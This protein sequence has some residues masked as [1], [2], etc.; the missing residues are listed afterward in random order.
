[1]QVEDHEES[2]AIL[3]RPAIWPKGNHFAASEDDRI[4]SAL[5]L[6]H[7]PLRSLGTVLVACRQ[8]VIDLRDRRRVGRG[9]A[10]RYRGLDLLY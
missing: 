8:I 4:R 6:D 3:R 2:E 5:G 7:E 9:S 1:M 10:L